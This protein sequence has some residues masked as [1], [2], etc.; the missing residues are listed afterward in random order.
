MPPRHNSNFSS[1]FRVYPDLKPN[2]GEHRATHGK[3]MDQEQ[4]RSGKKRRRRVYRHAPLLIWIG[5]IFFLSSGRG[6]MSQTSQIIKPILE[7][8]FPNASEST[9]LEYHAYIR[10]FAHFAEYGVLGLLA[11][12]SF[13]HSPAKAR[14]IYPFA[15]AF[16]LVVAVAA[17]DEFNQS[18][19]PARTAS[20]Q[21]IVIDVAGGLTMIALYFIFNRKLDR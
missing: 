1:A 11:A 20:V 5:V 21:D 12:I 4:Q 9:L 18:F 2:Y 8:L 13:S 14:Q 3:V 15:A 10:E 19:N 16:G 17:L 6:S 7:F